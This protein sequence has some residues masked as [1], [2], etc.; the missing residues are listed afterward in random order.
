M[1]QEPEGPDELD[2]RSVWIHTFFPALPLF[3]DTTS[4]ADA[5]LRNEQTEVET[6]DG[7]HA[8]PEASERDVDDKENNEKETEEVRQ[9]PVV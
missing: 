4:R 9:V 6:G 2:R 5:P 3:T 7:Q 8:G 1:L